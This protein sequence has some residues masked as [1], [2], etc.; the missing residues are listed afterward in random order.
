M[1]RRLAFR[2]A[3]AVGLL[4][5]VFGMLAVGAR[6]RSDFGETLAYSTSVAITAVFCICLIR[7]PWPVAVRDFQHTAVLIGQ[8]VSH[9]ISRFLL[10]LGPYLCLCSVVVANLV[11]FNRLAVDPDIAFADLFWSSMQLATIVGVVPTRCFCV[12]ALAIE[13]ASRR[14]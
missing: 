10:K 5:G 3:V 8:A 2:I 1:F 7:W 11:S 4:I 13:K 14:D 6:S 12:T 9:P